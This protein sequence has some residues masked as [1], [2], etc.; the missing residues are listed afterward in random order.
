M[1][2]DDARPE[3]AERFEWER[4][5][6]RARLGSAPTKSVALALA[7]YA[8]QDG[9]RVRPGVDRLAAVT[10]L[11]ERSVKNALKKL[12][13]V[14]LIERVFHGGL[15]GTRGFADVYRLTIPANLMQRV[16]LLPVDE[17][18]GAPGAAQGAARSSQGAP[19]SSQGA[20]GAPHH[21]S[22]HPQTTTTTTGELAYGT[23]LTTVGNDLGGE[24]I[25]LSSRGGLR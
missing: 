20:P 14:G 7:T 10:E 23:Q 12:R 22:N 4:I 24:V 25:S 1:V 5:I 6:R 9:T 18:Q 13:E 3:P 8:D 21:P 11:S 15:R 19:R 2:V 16:E 17:S